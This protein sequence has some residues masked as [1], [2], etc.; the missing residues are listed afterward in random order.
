MSARTPAGIVACAI[1]IGVCVLPGPRK[2]PM[3][4]A[5]M[6]MSAAPSGVVTSSESVPSM[7]W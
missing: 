4:P 5:M 6:R 3:E 7:L 1:V 2:P